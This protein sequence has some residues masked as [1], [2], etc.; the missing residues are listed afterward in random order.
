MK[1]TV[2]I[3]TYNGEKTINRAVQSVL[4]QSVKIETE[5]LICDDCSTDNTVYIAQKIGCTVFVNDKNSGGP[6]KGRNIG[7]I[8]ATGDYIA[9]LDQDD[10]WLPNKLE[11]QLRVNADVIYSQYVGSEKSESSNL[12]STLLKRDNTK[13]WAYLGSL[14]IKNNNIPL[15]EEYF[16]QLDYDWLLRLTKNRS[17]K[18]IAPVV[19]R[20][21]DGNNLSLNSEYRKR[22]FYMGLLLIDGDIR[23]MKKWYS[24]R[25]RYHY[26]INDM[27]MSRFYFI[28]G[29]LSIKTILYFISSY[30]LRLSNLI[31]KKFKVFG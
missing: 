13:G 21:V 19:K 25:A 14:L 7:I 10:E 28:R 23:V 4:N 24:S 17:C 27:K 2:I 11:I 20:N 3:P 9:F 31:I 22:D 12:Y 15:F 1:V 5:I 26:V 29:Q 18:Q 16:G 8:N 30:N 6:N